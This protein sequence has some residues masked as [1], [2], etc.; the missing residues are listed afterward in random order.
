[1]TKS[2]SVVRD[3]AFAVIG[4]VTYKVNLWQ[5]DEMTVWRGANDLSGTWQPDLSRT[6]Q[7][8]KMPCSAAS[9]I[10]AVRT[11]AKWG[12]VGVRI[13]QVRYDQNKATAFYI[14]GDLTY[15]GPQDWPKPVSSR[16][17]PRPGMSSLK[18]HGSDPDDEFAGDVCL[19][20]LTDIRSTEVEIGR[21]EDGNL[22]PGG[23]FTNLL[24]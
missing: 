17:P 10:F 1:M 4:G 3:G 5:L 8:E 24:I 6:P 2:R 13:A 18:S 9:R 12:D 22:L 19:E 16:T 14:V 11:F 7:I 21:D 23:R 15:C 20:E